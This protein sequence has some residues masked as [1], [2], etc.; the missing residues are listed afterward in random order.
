[1]ATPQLDF[2]PWS[3][4]PAKPAGPR[5]AAAAQAAAP[6]LDFDPFSDGTA[7]ND[8]PATPKPAAPTRTMGEA[9]DD[10]AYAIRRGTRSLVS[11]LAG[12]PVNLVNASTALPRTAAR[13]SEAIGGAAPDFVKNSAIPQPAFVRGLRE[14]LDAQDAA[15]RARWASDKLQTQEAEF[16]SKEGIIDSAKY[17]VKNPSLTGV[18][19]AEQLPQFL[20]RVPGSTAGTIGAQA[21]SAASQNAAQVERTLGADGADP[22]AIANRASDAFNASLLVNA[23]LPAAMPGGAV[24]ERVLAGQA[25]RTAGTLATRAAKGAA[26]E[27]VSGA[28]TEGLDQAIQNAASGRALGEGLG[29]ATA[30]G[31]VLGGAV[32]AP[33]GVLDASATPRQGRGPAGDTA[34][35]SDLSREALALPPP[36]RT[37]EH[38]VIRVGPYGEATT[39][40]QA[41]QARHP[42][43]P[44]PQATAESAIPSSVTA[45]IT[46]VPVPVRVPFPDAQ[47]G[48]LA[49]ASNALPQ[50]PSSIK[51]RLVEAVLEE[52]NAT[53]A[54]AAA[55]RT[56]A[57]GPLTRIGADILDMHADAL[58]AGN[59]EPGAIDRGRSEELARRG[60][61][62]SEPMLADVLSPDKVAGEARTLDFDPFRDV[63]AEVASL[64]SPPAATRGSGGNG[65]KIVNNSQQFATFSDSS[66]AADRTHRT[67]ETPVEVT[68][69]GDGRIDF[70][71]FRGGP[72]SPV[73]QAAS[74]AAT[75]P[76]NA[77]KEPTEAQKEAGNFAVGRLRVNGLDLSI[78]HPAGV[79]RKAEHSQA[80][81][82]A[83][84][85]FRRTTGADGEK[86]DAF[87]GDRATDTSLPVF[88]VDQK[89]A[90]GS[91]D[92]SKVMLGFETAA[93]ARAAYLSNYPAGWEQS[94]LG[95]IRQFSQDEFKAWVQD[96]KATKKPAVKPGPQPVVLDFDPH[97]DV[98]TGPGLR[99]D[100]A[101]RLVRRY[102]KNMP[103]HPRVVLVDSAEALH[104]AA[105]VNAQGDGTRA[106]GLW[107]GAPAIYINTAAIDSP[108]RFRQV[109][110][111]EA[112]GHVGVENVVGAQWPGIAR[113]ITGHI[114]NG[115][116]A[117]WMRKAIA[118]AQ[119]SQPGV[120]DSQ[121]L[122]REV[123]AVMAEQGSRNHVLQTIV[124][125][126][127]ATLRQAIPSV[128]WTDGDVRDLLSQAEGYLRSSRR[129]ASKATAGNEPNAGVQYSK[130]GQAPPD[131]SEVAQGFRHVNDEQR[132]ALG[133]INTHRPRESV[134]GRLE[135]LTQNL[136][137]KIVQGTVDQFHAFR[138][139]DETAYMQARLS[140]G[141][142]GAVEGV[143]RYGLPKLTDG[144]LD[145]Q[146]DGKGFLGHLQ[147]LQG[148]HDL[149]LAW[150]AGHR[151]DQLAQEGR[152]HLFTPADIA[153]L[154]A[155]H[156]GRMPDGQSR[157]V[158]YR[159]AL[160]AL[161]R[162][163]TAILD[164]A[165]EA[166]VV[167]TATRKLWNADFYVPFFRD[168][169][170]QPAPTAH[171]GRGGDEPGDIAAMRKAVIE[172]LVG[173]GQPLNDLLENTLQNW[174]RLLAASMRNM[175]AARALTVATDIGAARAMPTA[176][177]GTVSAMFHGERRHFL[178]DDPLVLESLVLLYAPPWSNPAMKGL[179]WF[180]RALTVG[181]TTDPTFRIRN[182]IRD[183]LSVVASNKIGFNPLQNLAQGW[184]ATQRGGDTFL[185]LLGGGGAI[186][187]GSVLDGDQAAHAK[188]LIESGLAA[189]GNIL[190]TPAKAKA[191]LVKLW[192]AYQELGDRAETMNRAALYEQARA[193]GKDHLQ[194]SFA[195]RDVLDFTNAGAW[196]AVQFLTRT[197]PFMNARL[198][199]MYKLGR[200]AKQ[201]P[202]RFAAVT[203]AVALAS[204][205]LHLANADDE[206]Y[207]ALPDW[208]RDTY[209]WVRI[210]GTGH[211]LYIPKPFEL[212]AL[213]SVV[214]RGT[215]LMTGGDDYQAR[216]FARTLLGIAESQLALNPT[217]QAVKPAIE[218]AF[219]R[220]TFQDRPI[221]GMGQERLPP[222][223]R[224]TARTS[225]GAVALGKLTGSSPQRIEHMVRGY[226]GWL[227]LQ[228]LNTSDLLTRSMLDLGS[229]PAHDFGKV[230]NLAVI[231]SFIKERDAAGSK[232]VN[233]FYEQARQVDMLYAAYS[234]A[235]QAGDLER[236]RELAADDRMKLRG[237]YTS[238][239][240]AMTRVNRE[241]RRVTNDKT[242]SP[243]AKGEL[244]AGLQASRERMARQ[245][246]ERAR[247]H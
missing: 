220:N 89:K 49:D 27:A 157:E 46:P 146:G 164:I 126:T 198:Q 207:R 99:R 119:A 142:D 13:L 187:F 140:R 183:T 55:M 147:A 150:V 85:Y 52:A 229:N 118:Q 154:K 244:L 95:G 39:S 155:L 41:A 104:R 51:Q 159:K 190:D 70:D 234:V 167:N 15:D 47:S 77:L 62:G 149:F 54:E 32:G 233:R 90:D 69:A 25:G 45:D 221:D 38:G 121:R 65:S 64:G 137:A 131:V 18:L 122:A 111:H 40:G 50:G 72:P 165:E 139:L 184:K 238:T 21:A 213:G 91:F 178:V 79:K 109:L 76:D 59:S 153:A 22:Q 179:Q 239:E 17:L 189:E 195:A 58:E 3:D 217:P 170:G 181:V 92:E 19:A 24:A 113:T 23:A 214:E 114:E 16:Q 117:P 93:E 203:G 224:Y 102:A 201:Y 200:G 160:Q 180:K 132:A 106:E 205:A 197:V 237:L 83:Y 216:D 208:V 103:N 28:A 87:L 240:T 125:R 188:R 36:D 30:L 78:E 5:P 192:D 138:D 48:T 185:K 136:R 223:D 97:R 101:E 26:G 14:G 241:I 127:R 7:A 110:A 100:H 2:D 196:T 210:P 134:S 31:G 53:R 230:D 176:E 8:V 116:G 228:A 84:G 66:T 56:T 232:Y 222:A 156:K 120:T 130:P 86:V 75:S 12:L 226:F 215:E 115:T 202:K 61:P 218:A 247:R 94:G 96:P 107:N 29:Q 212:G 175:A 108:K 98:T 73:A 151:S 81:S 71:P 82:H 211:A 246:T 199:G 242:L 141:T 74:S 68:S 169:E 20:V 168:M 235:R 204:V 209:W 166:D 4:A 35:T 44:R 42:G 225:G 152:E 171:P 63:P 133:K 206:D 10:T 186:R 174:G 129:S 162:Y 57:N 194:A 9:I 145:I 219:N 105:G 43:F 6:A 245:A 80:L 177:R 124:A 193:E 143:F 158:A 33:A 128:A 236:A 144:A 11:G 163:Q 37:S 172:R 191:G 135:R 227:G 148:E 88:V 161:N 243:E 112:L 67:A 231:G 60:S 1:M 34:P 123:L 173:G 182:L